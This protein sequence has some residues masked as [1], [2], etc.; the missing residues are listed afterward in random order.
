MCLVVPVFPDGQI[1]EYMISRDS[2]LFPSD[3]SLDRGFNYISYRFSGA[4]FVSVLR[5]YLRCLTE[6]L[7]AVSQAYTHKIL[8]FFKLTSTI[9]STHHK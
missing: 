6:S 9:Q 7:C 5:F 8:F 3:P 4:M 1:A 2:S